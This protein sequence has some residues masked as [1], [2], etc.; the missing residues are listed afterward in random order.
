MPEPDAAEAVLELFCKVIQEYLPTVETSP[1][2]LI[3]VVSML[4]F[5]VFP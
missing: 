3:W 2:Y 5:S 4:P 1:G